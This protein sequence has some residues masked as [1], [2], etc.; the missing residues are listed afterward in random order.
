MGPPESSF[1]PGK[2][3]AGRKRPPPSVAGWAQLCRNGAQV[4]REVNELIFEA[5]VQNSEEAESAT[6]KLRRQG[7][8]PSQPQSRALFRTVH[9]GEEMVPETRGV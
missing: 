4:Q 3:I 2:P 5:A 7:P 8:S 6:P 1:E 9:A